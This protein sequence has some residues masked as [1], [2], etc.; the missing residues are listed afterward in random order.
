MIVRA[1]TTMT[2]QESKDYLKDLCLDG[3]LVRDPEEKRY[4]EYR[5]VG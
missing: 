5:L 1:L 4:A 3:V 2:V